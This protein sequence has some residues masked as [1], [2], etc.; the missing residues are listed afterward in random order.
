MKVFTKRFLAFAILLLPLSVLAQEGTNGTAGGNGTTVLAQ[1]GTA[2]GTGTG[3]GGSGAGAG[4]GGGDSISAASIVAAINNLVNGYG[5][6]QWD[7]HLFVMS[8]SYVYSMAYAAA[9]GK[10]MRPGYIAQPVLLPMGSST[11]YNTNSSLSNQIVFNTLTATAVN[12]GR[13]SRKLVNT[14]CRPSGG[15]AVTAAGDCNI[16][17]TPSTSSY[18]DYNSL[19]GPVVYKDKGQAALNFIQFAAGLAQTPEALDFDAKV[20]D[21]LGS[22]TPEKALDYII[23]LRS[24][25]AAQSVGVTNLLAL[26]EERQAKDGLGEGLGKKDSAGRPDNK[27]SQLEVDEYSAKRRVMDKHWHTSM[28]KASPATVQ[29]EIL[30]VLSEMRLEMF[31]TRMELERLTSATSVMQLQNNDTNAQSSIEPTKRRLDQPPGGGIPGTGL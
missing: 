8:P 12:R 28:E 9:T 20:K 21:T 22:K 25:A 11:L 16:D 23:A 13:K 10:A 7:K 15:I 24:Y 4:G 29:R 19:V 3:T 1:E 6:D 30:Y 14:T 27:A 2:G 17:V 31:K 18:Y 26:Y 5:K